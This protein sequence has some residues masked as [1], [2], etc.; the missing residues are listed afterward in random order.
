MKDIVIFGAGG[1]GREAV[2][3]INI[4]INRYEPNTY[5]LLGFVVE[6]KYYK[7]NTVVNG[8]PVLGDEE[9]IFDHADT[10]CC[11]LAIGDHSYERER[12]FHM[13]DSHG[14]KLET[15]ICR[16]VYV[17]PTTIIGQGCYIATGVCLSVNMTIGNGVFINSQCMFGHDVVIGDFCNFYPR[18]TISGNCTF[19]RHASIGG[20][21]YIIPKR[22]IGDNSVIAPGSVVFNNVKSDT[23]VLGNPAKRIDL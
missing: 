17:P 13:L 22:K 18:A 23:H 21:A 1:L 5:N 3:L 19:G 10:V 12:I 2:V 16:N 11:A 20:A 15:L 7:A 8:Y 14:V 6:K 9:W 4:G